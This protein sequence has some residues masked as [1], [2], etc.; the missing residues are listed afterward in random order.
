MAAV[1]PAE[2]R[3]AVAQLV[4]APDCGSGGHP[5][6]PGRRYHSLKPTAL[7]PAPG[8]TPYGR[9]QVA[10]VRLDLIEQVDLR[11]SNKSSV[12]HRPVAVVGHA[13]EDR[14]LGRF[15]AA[16]GMCLPPPCPVEVGELTG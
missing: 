16:V 8:R 11:S 12:A 4:R 6:E 13:A 1:R 7:T 10:K 3:A 9:E 15:L 14:G 2:Y 5:F